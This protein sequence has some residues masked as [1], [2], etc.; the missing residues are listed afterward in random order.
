[1]PTFAVRQ[2]GLPFSQA[3]IATTVA[4]CVVFVGSPILA[5]VSDRYGRKPLLL[6]GALAFALLTYPAFVAIRIQPSLAKLAAAQSVFGLAMAMYAGPAISV[7]AQLFPTPRRSTPVARVHKIPHAVVA[8]LPP[9]TVP[10]LTAPPGTAF[11]HP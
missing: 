7:Y 8:A 5:A 2:L 1:M 6:V 3:L 10:C 11:A 9:L 4:G